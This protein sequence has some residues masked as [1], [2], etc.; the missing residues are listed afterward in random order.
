[1]ASQLLNMTKTCRHNSCTQLDPDC[2]GDGCQAVSRQANIGPPGHRT[3]Q[4]LRFHASLCGS[5][6]GSPPNWT[7]I[8]LSSTHHRIF[9]LLATTCSRT[10]ESILAST[11]QTC[12]K[13]ARHIPLTLLRNQLHHAA[14]IQPYRLSQTEVVST[15]SKQLRT[16]HVFIIA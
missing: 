11:P 9:H 3:P 16:H 14:S 1:M 15:S 7:N 12:S 13:Q 4:V 5:L 6:C 8:A 2:L 10:N